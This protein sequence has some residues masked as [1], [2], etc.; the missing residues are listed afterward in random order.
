MNNFTLSWTDDVSYYVADTAPWWW[1][2]NT[3]CLYFCRQTFS[4]VKESQLTSS[5]SYIQYQI[6]ISIYDKL[7]VGHISYNFSLV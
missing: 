3:S 6:D 1:K 2:S 7:A 5:S 4:L